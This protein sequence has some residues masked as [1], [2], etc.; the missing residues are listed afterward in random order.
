MRETDRL[1]WLGIRV[2]T[3][4]H[5]VMVSYD[6]ST[7]LVVADIQNDFVS[8]EGSLYVN[9]AEHILAFVNAEIERA[10]EAGARIVYTQD[11]HPDR[12]PHFAAY[13]GVW[14]V[15]CVHDT[16]GA[17]FHPELVFAGD[18]LRKGTGGEDG[19]SAFS[20]RDPTSRERKSTDLERRLQSWGAR[21][22]VVVGVATYYCV[23][24]TALDA[25]RLGFEATVLRDGVR[26]VNRVAGDGERAL[27]EMERAGVRLE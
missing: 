17:S 25:M 8:R 4:L 23:K 5:V 19:Y 16:W 12:T 1:G 21:R 14:P 13:G 24:E 15:H 27:R 22:V 9:G 7:A 6:P 26:A 20:V 3:L 11:W 18:V 10:R 2:A